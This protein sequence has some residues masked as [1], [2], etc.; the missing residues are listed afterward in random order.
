MWLIAPPGGPKAPLLG[1]STFAEM[2]L[3]QVLTDASLPV[4]VDESNY[5]DL[6]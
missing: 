6:Y 2:D 5:H 4:F 1:S 3:L